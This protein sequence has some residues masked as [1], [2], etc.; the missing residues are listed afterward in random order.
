MPKSYVDI[1]VPNIVPNLEKHS[2]TC[3][4]LRSLTCW[5]GGFVDPESTEQSIHEAY[6]ESITRAQHYIYIEN[7]FFITQSLNSC[8]VKNQVLISG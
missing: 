2:V 8:I 1:K 7:Q 3:Q 5:S 6:L 4:I